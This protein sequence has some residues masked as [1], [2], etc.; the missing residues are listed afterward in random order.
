MELIGSFAARFRG[1]IRAVTTCTVQHSKSSD[2][3]TY[4]YMTSSASAVA[5]VSFNL[6][7]TSSTPTKRPQPLQDGRTFG[8]VVSDACQGLTLFRE[9]FSYLNPMSRIWN[10]VFKA[11]LTSPTSGWFSF[12]FSSKSVRYRPTRSA[13]PWRSSFTITS[14]TARPMAHDTGLPPNWGIQKPTH[15]HERLHQDWAFR[16]CFTTRRILLLRAW[17]F[18]YCKWQA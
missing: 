8:S 14:R 7:L 9:L 15:T 10:Q 3:R 4:L 2:L 12:C 6:S 13:L 5:G 18:K 16:C 11:Y 17:Y 1:Q